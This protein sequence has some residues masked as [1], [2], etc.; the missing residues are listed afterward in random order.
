VAEV[1]DADI[2]KFGTR[3]RRPRSAAWPR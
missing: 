1:I 2:L 3:R